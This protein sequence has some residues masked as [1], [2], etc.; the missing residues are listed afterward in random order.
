M[1]KRE[2]KLLQKY[3]YKT[4]LKSGEP[5]EGIVVEIMGD[6]K[7]V[8]REYYKNDYNELQV[9]DPI[10]EIDFVIVSRMRTPIGKMREITKQ[11]GHGNFAIEEE[12]LKIIA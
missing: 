4:L 1:K 11:L 3:G 2:N 7:I 8:A 6:G 12:V 10:Q 9:G 5:Y